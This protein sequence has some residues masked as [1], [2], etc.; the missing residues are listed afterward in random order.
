MYERFSFSSS[1]PAFGIVAIFYVSHHNTCMVVL[2]LVLISISWWLMLLDAFSCL[3]I[4]WRL[5][6]MKCL[7][8]YFAHFLIGFFFCI[9]CW[10][11]CF[12]KNIFQMLV[13]CHRWVCTSF[14]PVCSLFFHPFNMSTHKTKVF[15]IDEVEFVSVPFCAL[16]S[17]DQV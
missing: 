15:N 11:L 7:C 8:I 13:F 5:S 14:S 17:W 10:D 1:L 9:C 16:F 4:L 12:L 3:L 6:W 2:L